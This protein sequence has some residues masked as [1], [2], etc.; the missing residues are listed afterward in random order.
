MPVNRR[1]YKHAY[2]YTHGNAADFL[3]KMSKINEGAIKMID[4]PDFN[5]EKS[6]HKHRHKR[7]GKNTHF[8]KDIVHRLSTS[9]PPRIDSEQAQEVTNTVKTSLNRYQNSTA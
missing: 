7:S 9:S 8:L 5:T 4:V 1:F 2:S 3:N 6:E